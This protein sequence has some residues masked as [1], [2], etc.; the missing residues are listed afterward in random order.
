[1]MNDFRNRVQLVGNLGM[2]PELI[3]F[4]QGNKLAK[5]SLATNTKFKNNKGETQQDVQWHNVVA[6]GNQADIAAKFQKGQQIAIEGRLVY[7][8]YEDKNGDK[9][10]ITEIVLSSFLILP[11]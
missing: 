8:N 10:F 4:E 11:A 7:R 6:W 1:M 5:F 2:D 9:K 3:T